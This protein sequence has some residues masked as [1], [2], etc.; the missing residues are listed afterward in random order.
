MRILHIYN[1]HRGGG[2]AD[3]TT[4]A[5]IEVLREQGVEVETLARDSRSLTPGLRGK[6][7][8]FAGGFYA[9]DALREFQRTVAA[10]R[11]DIV[12]THE[13]YPLIS[14]W[15]HRRCV[16]AGLP[17]VATCNDFRLSCPIATHYTRSAECHD[18]LG[19]HEFACVRRN[20][21]DNLAESL[22]YAGRGWFAR[23]MGLFHGAVD[24]FVTISQYQL[25][26]MRDRQGVPPERL[27]LNYCAIRIPEQPVAD[28]SQGTYVGYAG[29]FVTEKGVEVLLEACRLAR[30]PLRLAGDAPQHPAVRP[31]DDA[32]CVTTR[33]PAELADFYRGA[34]VMVVPSVW[35]E[36]FGIVAA[37]AMSHGVPVVVSRTGGL[38][39]SVRDGETGLLAEPGNARDLAHKI[40]RIWHSAELARRLGA[41]A[42]QHAAAVFSRRAHF[43]RLMQIYRE[44][45][46]ERA[47]AGEGRSVMLNSNPS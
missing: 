32:Q 37:E 39:G 40:G 16:Q 5:T 41:A 15:V 42:A 17:V 11:P 9:A 1:D 30:L 8:A 7:Q 44:V 23:R 36:T 25:D 34:R 13:L 45:L 31:E 43:E 4:A 28:P 12:H 47:G 24:R 14:P 46:A 22:A 29:R 2:G 21:R 20:C 10:R 27:A 26:F 18:C 3:R 35:P 19:G 33:S 6:V 38:Q